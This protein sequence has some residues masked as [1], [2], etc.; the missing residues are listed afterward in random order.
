MVTVLILTIILTGCIQPHE[1]A[2]ETP[3]PSISKNDGSALQP[4]FVT[5]VS[6]TALPPSEGVL[7]K[8]DLKG[9]CP[10]SAPVNTSI[11][12]VSASSCLTLT[13]I[14]VE[15]GDAILVRSPSGRI[16]LIDAGK[17][18]HDDD[19]IS[20]L[21]HQGVASID[22]L[23][24]TH[25]HG[26]HIGGM[27]AVIAAFPV[28][29]FIES[30]V[31][32]S[33]S[34][35]RLLRATLIAK[36]IPI[37]V[38]GKGDSIPFDPAVSVTVLNP[39]AKLYDKVN[40]NSL[41]L[42]LSYGNTTVLLTG[43]AGK[44]AEAGMIA[45]GEPLKADVLKAGHHGLSSSTTGPFVSRVDPAITVIS[46]EKSTRPTHPDPAVIRRLYEAGSVLYRTDRDG[47]VTIAS[48]GSTFA[49]ISGKNT[50]TPL[51]RNPAIAV[52]N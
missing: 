38:V 41:I 19:V 52:L 44:E 50:T 5:P 46:L 42:R 33:S 15:Q 28:R 18:E 45:A 13:F 14:D 30:A 32:C 34:E 21:R 51:Y 22:I 48:N 43:D 4:V 2:A 7:V 31:P 3:V 37:R 9:S 49:V 20:A 11:C 23:V 39:P 1:T 35:C 10:S 27:P 6:G 47:T 24:V 17:E 12:T 26:D 29:Q 40:E 8:A 36:D 16:L 25:P